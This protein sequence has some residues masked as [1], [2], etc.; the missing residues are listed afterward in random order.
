MDFKPTWLYVKECPHCGLLYFGKT[1]SKDPI[2]YRGSGTY[3]IRHLGRHNVIPITRKV[4]R[5]TDPVK[6]KA[7][8]ARF[9]EQHGVADSKRW[10]NLRDEDGIGAGGKHS[11]RTRRKIS[12]S[13]VGTMQW[14]TNGVE[15]RM[16][17]VEGR[18]P[19][20][21]KPGRVGKKHDDIAKEKCRLSQLG[22][23][24]SK[25]HRESLSNASVGRSKSADH[26][27]A[28]SRSRR[29]LKWFNDGK[30]G[31]QLFDDDPL[32]KRLGLV[33]GRILG[34]WYTDG[35]NSFRMQPTDRNIKRLGLRPG[36]TL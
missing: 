1:T 23:P 5:Y 15:N 31:Y 33:R 24:K 13:K 4:K 20:G 6:I 32:I 14:Y 30:R 12:L 34:N 29:G 26:V 36:R 2:A 21:F 17:S 9:S 28:S 16:L 22:V 35:V 19:R 18:I 27:L 3:W 25:A 10:A 11:K 7:A 8:A